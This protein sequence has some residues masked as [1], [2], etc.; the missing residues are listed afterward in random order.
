MAKLFAILNMPD[1]NT[2]H[3][4]ENMS[5]KNHSSLFALLLFFVLSLSLFALERPNVVVVIVDDMGFSDLGCYGGESRPR[6]WTAWRPAGFGLRSFTTP[7]DVGRLA[8][9]S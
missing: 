6:T 7:P 2:I 5:K 4:E 3:M 8:V 1:G 9:R